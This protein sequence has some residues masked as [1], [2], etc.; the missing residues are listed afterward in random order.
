VTTTAPAVPGA[1][2]P[3]VSA[4]KFTRRQRLLLWAASAL[5]YF[6][7]RLISPTLRLSVSLEDGAREHEPQHPSIYCFWHRGVF[8]ATYC[9]RNHRIAVMTSRSFDGEYIARIIERAGYTAV[10]GSSS[11]GGAGALLGMHDVIENG[12][13]VAFTADGPRGP[14][15]VTKPGPILLARN[16]GVPIVAF[17]IA[18]D[19][20]WLLPSWDEF[21]V[22]KPFSRGLLRISRPLWVPREAEGDALD[23]FHAE[24]QQTLD[25]T[26]MSAEEMLAR[27]EHRRLPLHRWTK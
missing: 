11:R 20:P 21:M 25:R 7:I 13:S 16:T 23:A 5:G 10:R 1:A 6:A 19:D 9:F 2:P 26:R 18:L 27:G 12:F 17:H 8:A 15:Y 22:P 24:L 3:E 4:R 14:R